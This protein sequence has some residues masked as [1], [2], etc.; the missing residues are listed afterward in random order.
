MPLAVLQRGLGVR[1]E[2]LMP[3]KTAP[4]ERAVERG[5][6]LPD[7]ITRGLAANE[8]LKYYLALLQAAQAHAR[9]PHQAMPLLRLQREA[10]G[11]SDASL[12]H[13]VE[14]SV[15]RAGNT[16]YIPGGCAIV[17]SLFEELRVMLQPLHAASAVHADLRG[18]VGI[19]ERRLDDL[20]AHAPSC[21]DDQIAAATIAALTRRAPNGHD[22]LHQL[23]TDLSDELGRLRASVAVETV[24]GASVYNVLDTDRPWIAAYMKGI[25]ETVALKFDHPGLETTATHDG[26]RL[27]IQT[28]LGMRHS[29]P[30]QI[31]VDG[32]SVDITYS[33]V[34]HA[35]VAFLRDML[36][37]YD[38][39]W[40]PAARTPDDHELIAGRY[41]ADTADGVARFLTFLGSRLV[42]LI[43][44]NRARK[45]LGRLVGKSEAQALLHWAAQNNVGHVA[46]LKAGDVRLV[47][48]ALERAAP[49]RLPPGTR[50]DEW[51]G[52]EDARWLLMSVLGITSTGLRSGHSLARITENVEA[53]LAGH[54]QTRGRHV[55]GDVGDQATM[56]TALADRVR[57]SLR[58][59]AGADGSDDVVA[60]ELAHGW[61]DHDEAG[62]PHTRR[63]SRNGDNTHALR[64]LWRDADAAADAI[65][66]TLFLLSLVPGPAGDKTVAVLGEL[67]EIV[68]LT[69]REYARCVDESGEL[70]PTSAP[71]D[72]EGF[73][74]TV[75]RLVELGRQA[76]AAKRAVIERVLV[77]QAS[78]GELHLLTGVAQSLENAAAAL[79]RCGTLVRDYVL[80][81]CLNR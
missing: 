15:E 20:V 81:T 26:E 80:S 10:S 65:E 21:S 9:A 44:W 60:G 69:V 7:L 54:L 64:P 77:R 39:Q 68:G 12:D 31:H 3:T 62:L 58:H 78:P 14:G 42:F 52:R 67:P 66:E 71:S 50:L 47:Q 30:V 79:S 29:S 22:T 59:L 2:N 28:D 35:R 32:L 55:F 16:L 75:D 76:R 34:H 40:G 27:A 4:A 6:L 17:M 11:I 25:A 53:E 5:L 57:R 51:V 24:A 43:W 33:E 13:I 61:V 8:R 45:R 72:V 18:R 36:A 46:F 48:T 63:W 23:V 49:V 74:T 56:I 19:Y 70:S 38:V 1:T 37:P 73:L 41:I